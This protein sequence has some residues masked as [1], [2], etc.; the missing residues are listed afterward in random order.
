MHWSTTPQQPPV[1]GSASRKGSAPGRTSQSPPE[2]KAWHEAASPIPSVPLPRP[3]PV[4]LLSCDDCDPHT[5]PRL[6]GLQFQAF[7]LLHSFWS[8]INTA[9]DPQ[10]SSLPRQ[11][12]LMPRQ[13]LARPHITTAPC[14]AL[15]FPPCPPQPSTPCRRPSCDIAMCPICEAWGH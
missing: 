12:S 3:C 2:R 14:M 5:G 15:S 6:Y 10:P 8:L 11:M 4:P 7:L 9:W 1:S 13:V